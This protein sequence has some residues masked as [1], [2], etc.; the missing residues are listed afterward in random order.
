[1]IAS[2][3]A[4][5]SARSFPRRLRL[6]RQ[7]VHGALKFP[8]QR[9]V[10]HAMAFDPALP[11]EGRRHDINSKVRLAARPVAG[12][13]LMQVRFVRD[14]EAFWRESFKQ[15]VYDNVPGAHIGGITLQ[16]RFPS[17]ARIGK[18]GFRNVKTCSLRHCVVKVRNAD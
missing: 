12:M 14:I 5:I 10:D 13:A 2:G 15:L 8:G 16:S 17:M 18:R 11:F 9:P 1:M 3:S 4:Q 6:D 7:R